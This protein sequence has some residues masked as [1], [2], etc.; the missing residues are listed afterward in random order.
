MSD[1]PGFTG[2]PEA[3]GVNVS[4]IHPLKEALLL[5]IGVTGGA[6]V[7][8]IVLVVVVEAVAPLMPPALE[9]R[10]FGG[11]MSSMEAEGSG[12]DE[13]MRKRCEGVLTDLLEHWPEAPYPFRIV[14]QESDEINAFAVPGGTIEVT[15]GLL[16]SIGDDD[17]LAFVLG[18]ELG[19]FA[20]RDHLRGMG[21]AV[22]LAV[23]SGRLGAGGVARPVLILIDHVDQLASKSIE[24]Q[25]EIA[26]DAFGLRLLLATH[27]DPHGAF[28]F[29]ERLEDAETGHRG[30]TPGYLRTHPAT[31]E[32]LTALKAANA[33]LAG[34]V[35]SRS[36]TGERR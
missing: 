27:G 10:V 35:S 20:H 29:L 15:T 12:E 18:H 28:A 7:V 32:R 4:P 22:V 9:C 17:E 33:G 13:A 11:G 30:A 36:S 1:L 6:M 24:R 23:I 5:V 21:R 14:I 19:H 26:A 8:F 31:S 2:K 34:P 25:Q 3:E 16:K